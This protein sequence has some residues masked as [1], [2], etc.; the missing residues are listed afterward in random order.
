LVTGR[1]AHSS[2]SVIYGGLGPLIVGPLF[3]PA[4][5]ASYD[6]LWLYIFIGPLTPK[7]L[8]AIIKRSVALGWNDF[9]WRLL[10]GW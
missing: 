7:L 10:F 5:S 3:L 2:S 1:Y 4:G 8:C 9:K 6:T